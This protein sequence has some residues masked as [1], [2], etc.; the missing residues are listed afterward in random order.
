[1]KASLIIT[2]YKD[3]EALTAVLKSLE[4]QT[5]KDF[6]IIVA[7]DCDSDCFD[8]LI[9]N[10]QRQGYSIQH[11]QQ[12]DN[13]FQKNKILN[14]AILKTQSTT[15]IFIDGDCVLHPNFIQTHVNTL[16]KGFFC[17]GRRVNLDPKNSQKIRKGEITTPSLTSM[18]FKKASMV[19]EGIPFLRHFDRKEKMLLGCNMSFHK[20]DIL[21][22]N[23]FDEDYTFPG[24]GEDTDIEFR[25]IKLGLKKKSVRY[26]AIQYHLFHERSDREDETRKSRELYHQKQLNKDYRCNNGIEK[27]INAN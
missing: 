17:V 4:F 27:L 11:L 2:V 14:K 26:R 22:L 7:Q 20:E 16:E 3:V 19:E 5:E 10:Y 6:E 15:L 12:E 25:A 23:G 24:Y 21:Q 13:G 8:I 18:L 9:N 1:M